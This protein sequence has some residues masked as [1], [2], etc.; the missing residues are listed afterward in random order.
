MV[1]PTDP[2]RPVVNTQLAVLWTGGPLW[3]HSL[4]YMDELVSSLVCGAPH[5]A[6]P[7]CWLLADH[8][9]GHI[10]SRG[11]IHERPLVR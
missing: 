2:G 3:E 11:M 8:A 9:G 5:P 10:A 7:R 1:Y 6:G 4:K